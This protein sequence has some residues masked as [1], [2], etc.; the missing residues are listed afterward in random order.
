[1]A[2]FCRSMGFGYKFEKYFDT[3]GGLMEDD[4]KSNEFIGENIRTRLPRTRPCEVTYRKPLITVD[5]DYKVCECRDVFG[6]LVIGSVKVQSFQEMWEGPALKALRDRF[7]DPST[8]PEI[9]KK[10][11]V[12]APAR[13]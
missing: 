12:Y 7:Y 11:E 3:W 9:C 4:I 10:C 1:M 13:L 8:L 5:G 6:E 2:D